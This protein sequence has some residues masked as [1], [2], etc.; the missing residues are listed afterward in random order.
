MWLDP[1]TWT[2]VVLLSNAVY[3]ADGL[4]RYVH[5][6]PRVSELA[7]AILRART[8][9]ALRTGATGAW[10]PLATGASAGDHGG[11]GGAESA[12]LLHPLDAHRP[13]GHPPR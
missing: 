4:R 12:F 10:I 2:Y 1:D 6:R 11:R 7:A 8:S 9:P 13:L 5:V 3:D